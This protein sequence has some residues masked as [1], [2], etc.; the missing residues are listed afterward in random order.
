MT[1]FFVLFVA[2]LVILAVFFY[3]ARRQGA[4]LRSMEDFRARWQKVDLEAFANLVDPSEERFLME[5]LPSEEY[6]RIRRERLRAAWE[7]LSRVGR[8]A[9]LM[10]QAGQIIQAHNA[11]VEAKRARRHVE[12]AMSLRTQVVIAQC[13]LMMQIAFPTGSPQLEKVLRLYGDAAHSFDNVL[14]PGVAAV[15]M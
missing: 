11:G 12:Q 4:Q 8:N 1:A 3:A 2:A 7:Y 15:T 13:S 5:N 6:R 10:V 14:D 9:Q